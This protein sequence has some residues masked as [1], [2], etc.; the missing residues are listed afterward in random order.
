[1]EVQLT[2]NGA[3]EFYSMVYGK[4]CL[5]GIVQIKKLPVGASALG[6]GFAVRDG[7]P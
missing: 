1:M 3:T 5:N 4:I 6:S 2:E 7:W